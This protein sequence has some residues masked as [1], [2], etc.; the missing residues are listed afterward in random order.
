M[1]CEN[2][3]LEWELK[4]PGPHCQ[5][6]E[7]VLFFFWTETKTSKVIALLVTKKLS[8][9]LPSC[10]LAA[11]KKIFCLVTKHETLAKE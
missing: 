8:I 9:V 6:S 3:N 10:K 7:S 2:K 11:H 4:R 1:E 5:V